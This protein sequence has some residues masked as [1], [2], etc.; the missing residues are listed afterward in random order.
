MA[1]KARPKSAG[2]KLADMVPGKDLMM[3][4][5]PME[6]W[7]EIKEMAKRDGDEPGAVISKALREYRDRPG[8]D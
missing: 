7:T 5:V 8:R 6:T 1:N 3:I 4:F 2:E